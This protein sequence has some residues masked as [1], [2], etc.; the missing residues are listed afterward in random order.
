[1]VNILV[2][3][4]FSRLSKVAVQYAMRIAETLDG[5]IT[6]LHVIDF[7]RTVTA[8]L[9]MK[10]GIREQLRPVQ[11]ELTAISHEALSQSETFPIIRYK[12]SRGN[13]FS[14]T[15]LRESK[16]LHSGLIIMGTK[17]ASG[18]KKTL[19][20]SNTASVLASS[21]IPV[22]VVPERAEFQPFRN[23]V[24]ATDMKH[25]EEELRMLIPYVELFGAVIHIL[26]IA[27]DASKMQMTEERIDAAV[28][29]IGYKNIVTLVTLDQEI[30]AAIENYIRVSRA[31]LLAMFTHK[32]TFYERMMDK[33]V[34]R[35][36]SFYTSIPLLA[37]NKQ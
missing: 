13:T 16:R 5:N 10:T 11:A 18:L 9:K 15:I 21:H 22:L 28:K 3:T 33:S 20:G 36:L 27:E 6:M 29:A 32:P 14:E 8:M 19:L 2:P 37:F 25:L 26:H 4:D 17:G 1:M 30:D 35:K 31:D 24:Y 7:Q 34:T 12:I 23:V